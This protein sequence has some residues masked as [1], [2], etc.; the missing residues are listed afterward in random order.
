[1]RLILVTLNLGIERDDAYTLRQ[2]DVIIP[3]DPIVA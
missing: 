1:M 2:Q 3:V